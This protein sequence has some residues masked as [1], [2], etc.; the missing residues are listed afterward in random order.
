[1]KIGGLVLDDLQRRTVGRAHLCAGG[2]RGGRRPMHVAL[3]DLTERSVPEIF[4]DFVDPP[5][6]VRDPVLHAADVIV[7]RVV[8]AVVVHSLAQLRQDATRGE[9][10]LVP[11]RR[12]KNLCW[13]LRGEGRISAGACTAS[14]GRDEGRIPAGA[15]KT[16]RG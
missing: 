13:C 15:R 6:W 14:R 5:V 8:E 3:Q 7:L 4:Q 11:A 9:S 16:D 12:G 1:M 2:A 10:L